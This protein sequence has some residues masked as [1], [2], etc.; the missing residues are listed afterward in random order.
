MTL[1]AT[2]FKALFQQ[3]DKERQMETV[4]LLI[5][6]DNQLEKHLYDKITW[7]LYRSYFKTDHVLRFIEKSPKLKEKILEFPRSCAFIT[8]FDRSLSIMFD[9][10]RRYYQTKPHFMI[11]GRKEELIDP[12]PFTVS[13]LDEMRNTDD[14]Y[15]CVR[16]ENKYRL[17]DF[18]EDLAVVMDI[19]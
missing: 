4:D 12:Q 11:S 6:G 17:W 2:A 5:K 16:A 9:E 14:V 7:N 3:L 19:G 8:E 15:F 13:V 1:Q 10:Y 18:D